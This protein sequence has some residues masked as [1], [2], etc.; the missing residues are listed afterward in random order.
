MHKE[1]L[2]RAQAPDTGDALIVP[3]PAAVGDKL[4]QVDTPALLLD[5]DAFEEN[6]RAMQAMLE[7]AGVR[8]RAHAKAHRCPEIARRQVALGAIGICCQKV[9][10]AVPFANAGIHDILISNEVIG[11][12]KL[13]LLAQLAKRARITVCVDSPAGA[14]ALS[15]ALVAADSRVTVL[16]DVDVGQKRCGVQSPEAL[17]ALAI[18]VNRLP[19]LAFGGIQAY[20]GGLQHKRSHAQRKH[21][22]EVV[23]GKVK[24]LKQALAQAG[25]ACPVV[26]G[27]G[28]GTA[29]F[30]AALGEFT[31]I[32]AGSYAF[33][34]TDYGSNDWG[35]DLTFRNSLFVWSTVISVP[36]AERVVM[37]AGLKSMSGESGLPGVS[38]AAGLKCVSLSDEHTVLAVDAGASAPELGAKLA[39]IPSHVDPTFNLHTTLVGVRQGKV[40]GL[41]EIQARGMSR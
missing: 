40:A 26:S 41:W 27:G 31:E 35:D 3:P 22:C 9:Q 11:P 28:T 25:L 5:L 23:A 29:E 10:E 32:Q 20:H 1:M 37:D 6:L 16:V 24:R 2:A 34:D 7:R 17:V 13:A 33:M 18:E 8:L 30:D 39:L 15:D 14:R 4:E 21:A 12:A 38:G 36:T 19:M